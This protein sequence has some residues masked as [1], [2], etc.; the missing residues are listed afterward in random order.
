MNN[1]H[2]GHY[3]Q[4]GRGLGGI[5]ASIMR[6]LKPIVTKTITAGRKALSDP[7]MKKAVSSVK[8]STIRA[9]TRAINQQMNKIAP[10]KSPKPANS[11][12]TIP[13]AKKRIARMSNIIPTKRK[14]IK[15]TAQNIFNDFK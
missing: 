11:S 8:K 15:K 9:G 14:K 1:I 4:R 7:A 13:K 5:F 12:I 6:V 2:R 10:S 3:L